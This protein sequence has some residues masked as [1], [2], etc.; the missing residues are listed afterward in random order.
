MREVTE[1]VLVEKRTVET[2]SRNCVFVVCTFKY[3]F[4]FTGF[5]S[6]RKVKTFL[7]LVLR[8]K[9]DLTLWDGFI[10]M[11]YSKNRVL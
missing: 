10:V 3:T 6:G 1:T 4:L 7:V 2:R 11:G 5:T 8:M 9:L